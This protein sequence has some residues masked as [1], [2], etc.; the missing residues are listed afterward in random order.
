MDTVTYPDEVVA[1]FI[2]EH[3][4]PVKLYIGEKDPA[5]REV[6]RKYRMLWAPG[7]VVLDARGEEVRRFIGYQPP[8]DFIAE[9]RIGLGKAHILHRRNDEAFGHFR[10]VADLD[11]AA[12]VSDEGLYW[13]GIALHYRDRTDLDVLHQYWKELERRFPGSRWWTAANVF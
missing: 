10:A 9:L 11:P 6:I 12:P 5:I 13:A 4:E 8:R 1:R 3:F 2:P 7:Y